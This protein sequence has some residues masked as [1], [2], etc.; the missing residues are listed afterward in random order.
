VRN[1]L[2]YRGWCDSPTWALG[3][4][5]LRGPNVTEIPRGRGGL[6]RRRPG[7]VT[8]AVAGSVWYEDLYLR[9]RDLAALIRKSG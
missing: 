4:A 3:L 2:L 7:M 9:A 5:W 6:I 1:G 8:V